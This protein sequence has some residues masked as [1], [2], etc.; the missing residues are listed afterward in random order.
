[1]EYRRRT[2]RKKTR[3]F[4]TYGKGQKN[5]E[6]FLCRKRPFLGLDFDSKTERDTTICIDIS[7]N[8][9]AAIK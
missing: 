4:V 7:E 2:A 6:I 9:I 1:M 3:M 8:F 5:I